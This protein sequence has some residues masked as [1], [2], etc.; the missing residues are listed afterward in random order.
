ML[1]CVVLKALTCII[2]MKLV[3]GNLFK[4]S[5]VAHWLEHTIINQK[6]LKLFPVSQIVTFLKQT[7]F[8]LKMW[9]FFSFYYKESYYDIMSLR[10]V[11]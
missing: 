9:I 10:Y 5:C 2:D 1:P 4:I 7:L 8:I 6:F 11:C 3:S